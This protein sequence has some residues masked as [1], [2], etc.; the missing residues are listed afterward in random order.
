M[1]S[2]YSLT[3]DK[4]ATL[5]SPRILTEQHLNSLY[6]HVYRKRSPD[7]TLVTGI[8]KQLIAKLSQYPAGPIKIKTYEQSK[9][10]HSVKF[11]FEL[12]DGN[13]IET[14]LMPEANRLTLCLS[15]QVGCRQACTFCHT[16]RLGLIRNLTTAE[17]V[18]QVA[19]ALHWIDQNP[20]WSVVAK[21]APHVKVSN[22]VF[23]GMGEPLDNTPAIIDSV[24]IFC[25]TAGLQIA[26]RRISVSTSGH[27]DGMKELF[28][29]LPKVSL[30]LSLHSP[31]EQE[32]S[33]VMP[34][35]RRWSIKE[36]LDYIKMK[37]AQG[38]GTVFVQYTLLGGVNDSSDHARALVNL[39][40]GMNV[41]VN[42]IPFNAF[43]GTLF[44]APTPEQLAI[45]R[46]ILHNSSI[47][48]M[49][50]FSKGQDIAAACGQLANT[51]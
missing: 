46:D 28:E 19:S 38:T 21:A 4:I 5:A 33:K 26:M 11:L 36:L 2:F 7:P 39:L 34:I 16:G 10:D 6:S 23:M 18:G 35:N 42:L 48:V 44:K 12:H 24:K 3:P 27:L 47:R 17:I 8:P 50:R 14:V 31:F 51:K 13:C 15:S 20:E 40:E 37:Q 30:A 9:Y 43:S 22:I 41:K 45:F 1:Q 29:S 25:H 49:V 32:R